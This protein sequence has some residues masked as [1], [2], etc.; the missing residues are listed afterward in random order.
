M[1]RWMRIFRAARRLGARAAILAEA[2]RI[3][4]DGNLRLP[5]N[6]AGALRCLRLLR[7]SLA[8]REAPECGVR[9][10][11]R[12]GRVD[13]LFRAGSAPGDEALARLAAPDVLEKLAADAGFAGLCEDIVR[14]DLEN[15][16]LTL[17][18]VRVRGVVAELLTLAYRAG[19]SLPE[20]LQIED[21]PGRAPV[22][23]PRAVSDGIPE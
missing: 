16:K 6:E 14:K 11:N 5:G 19:L 18:L 4:F 7:R 22:N 1:S 12:R 23:P 2:V 10:L 3:V 17:A 20:R 15:K 9:L 21:G 13:V 8:D